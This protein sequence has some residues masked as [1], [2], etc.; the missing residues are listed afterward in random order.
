MILMT[1]VTNTSFE[2]FFPAHLPDY[3]SET[4]QYDFE[5]WT[6]DALHGSQL[7]PH[8]LPADA[9]RCDDIEQIYKQ[10]H[11]SLDRLIS[12]IPLCTPSCQNQVRN[13]NCKLIAKIKS[14]E[15]AI[16]KHTTQGA[17]SNNSEYLGYSQASSEP[18]SLLSIRDPSSTGGHFPI[19]ETQHGW[20]EVSENCA[21][22]V[23]NAPGERMLHHASC[24]WSSRAS[25]NSIN[26]SS[27]L[28]KKLLLIGNQEARTQV[29]EFSMQLQLPRSS[30]ELPKLSHFPK[31]TKPADGHHFLQLVIDLGLTIEDSIFVEQNARIRK[32]IAMAHFYHAYTLAQENPKVFLSWCD[33][34]GVPGYS[35]LPKGG[36]KSIVQRRFADLIFSRDMQ[37]GSDNADNVKRRV[38]KVQMWRKS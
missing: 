13:Q 10:I 6:E 22:P 37:L 16:N 25:S 29:A 33:H 23:H 38:A 5:S 11:Q 36:N 28:A 8:L 2:N 14:L 21:T 24:T 26:H 27:K 31:V 3:Q 30:I 35:M 19:A 32:R 7:P 34:Q 17:I 4:I 12:R 20:L 9:E 1:G 15:N 18:S